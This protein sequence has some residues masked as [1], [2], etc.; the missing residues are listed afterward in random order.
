MSNDQRRIVRTYQQTLHGD[1]KKIFS[2]LCPVREK[3]WL[4]GWNYDMVYSKSGYAEKGCVFQTNNEF[5]SFQWVMTKYDI[6]KF[7]IQ[8]VKFIQN[9]M[10]VMIDIDLIDGEADSVY[11]NIQYT[12]TALND[13]VINNMHEENKTE[14]FNKHMKLWEDSLNY[15]LKTRKMFVY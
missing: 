8:F 4:Q 15:F 12:F 2:L 7:E 10:V 3:E 9:K 11:C 14:H 6:E 1:R 5:G 13:E